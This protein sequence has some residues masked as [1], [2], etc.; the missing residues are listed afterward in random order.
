M[1]RCRSFRSASFT[2]SPSRSNSRDAFCR[3]GNWSL[4]RSAIMRATAF[5]SSG[6]IGRSES[7]RHGSVCSCTAA[8]RQTALY[9]TPGLASRRSVHH[10]IKSSLDGFSTAGSGRFTIRSTSQINAEVSRIDVNAIGDCQ[11]V[12]AIAGEQHAPNGA[13]SAPNLPQPL[14]GLD[15]PNAQVALVLSHAIVLRIA[16]GQP[17]A[18]RREG[19][20]GTARFMAGQHVPIAAGAS[21]PQPQRG[22]QVARGK[23]FVDRHEWTSP[24]RRCLAPG[25]ILPTERVRFQWFLAQRL[26]SE[27]RP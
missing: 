18:V 11:N 4:S 14:A 17:F 19:H 1:L 12:P 22:V 16:G 5:A 20:A 26:D 6:L 23:N 8:K 24:Q 2:V 7:A 10:L 13:G 9:A 15:I 21:I 27:P 25:L 3:T